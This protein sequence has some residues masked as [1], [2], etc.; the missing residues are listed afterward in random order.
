MKILNVAISVFMLTSCNVGGENKNVQSGDSE[1]MISRNSISKTKKGNDI[2]RSQASRT[3]EEQILGIWAVVGDE[4]ATFVIS[5]ETITYPDQN[6]SYRY[7]LTN[8]S[9]YVKFDRYDDQYLVTMK[10]P[11]TLI[12]KGDEKQVYYRFRN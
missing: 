6:Q 11:D 5:K 9:L 3:L 4:N 7:A 1:K 10:G 8:D 12:L 2:A